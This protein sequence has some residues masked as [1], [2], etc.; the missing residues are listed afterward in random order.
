MGGGMGRG[1]GRRGRGGGAPSGGEGERASAPPLEGLALY[2]AESAALGRYL[3]RE[4]DDLIGQ[5]VD[6]QVQGQPLDGV[7]SARGLGEMPKVE[8]DWRYWVSQHASTENR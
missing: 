8:S 5:L 1:G 2:A 4:G 3:S 7:L 6:A